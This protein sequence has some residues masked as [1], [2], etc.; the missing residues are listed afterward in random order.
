VKLLIT[1]NQIFW[2]LEEGKIANVS[3][4]VMT[5]HH[6]THVDAPFHVIPGGKKLDEFPI[7]RWVCPAHVIRIKDKTA[8]R[9][10]EL[11]N[12]DIRRGDALLFKTHNSIS[13]LITKGGE[14]AKVWVYLSIE[15]AE[16]CVE[17]KVGLIGIDYYSIELSDDPTCLVHRKI[18]G[19]DILIL[20]A[21]NLA[22]VPVGEYVLCCL[23]LKLKG[24]DGAPARA[25]LIR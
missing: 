8:I 19:N 20:E 10:A 25:V 15:A 23:P 11:E 7:E 3:K 22:D 16:F 4:L 18:L 24:A 5:T 17:K 1:P 6:G 12:L 2:K 21:I 14:K 9:P 13:G